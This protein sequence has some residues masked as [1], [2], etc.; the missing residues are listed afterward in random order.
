MLGFEKKHLKPHVSADEKQP[1]RKKTSFLEQKLR[2]GVVFD[3]FDGFEK[4]ISK[5]TIFKALLLKPNKSQWFSCSVVPPFSGGV[6][7]RGRAELSVRS[8]G[9]A[10]LAGQLS[11]G[12]SC[13]YLVTGL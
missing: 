1:S 9:R 3:G 8:R 2:F 5:N 13:W 10:H 4:N 7:S 11:T 6:F 12:M